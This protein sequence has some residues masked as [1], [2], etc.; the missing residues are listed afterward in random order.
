MTTA[1]QQN[2]QATT[3][4]TTATQKTDRGEVVWSIVLGFVMCSF[5]LAMRI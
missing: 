4:Q 1:T 3:E 5:F 2:T